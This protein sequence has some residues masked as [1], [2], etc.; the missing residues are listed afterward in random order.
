MQAHL[1]TRTCIMRVLLC[2][3]V[4]YMSVQIEDNWRLLA[5]SCHPATYHWKRQ[6]SQWNIN[7][8]SLSQM[9]GWVVAGRLH[10]SISCASSLHVWGRTV[11]HLWLNYSKTTKEQWNQFCLE[12][13]QQSYLLLVNWIRGQEWEQ[14]KGRHKRTL[15]S[16]RLIVSPSVTKAWIETA[17]Q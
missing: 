16:S 3:H 8:P 17:L 9:C 1:G 7:K 13:T 4:S 14:V 10:S 11:T 5:P 2:G 12:S 15:C 6:K